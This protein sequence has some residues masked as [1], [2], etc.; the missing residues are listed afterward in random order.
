MKETSKHRILYLR[1]KK[2]GSH[3]KTDTA[4]ETTKKIVKGLLRPLHMC[5]FEVRA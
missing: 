5:L 4:S 1:A 2:R 3:V